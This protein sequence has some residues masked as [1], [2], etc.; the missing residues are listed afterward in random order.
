MDQMQS[1]LPT[2]THLMMNA[3]ALKNTIESAR[4]MTVAQKGSRTTFHT[5]HRTP[6]MCWGRSGL[7]KNNPCAACK[8]PECGKPCRIFDQKDLSDRLHC[9]GLSI[10]KWSLMEMLP[11]DQMLK[12]HH[13]HNVLFDF[14]MLLPRKR[15]IRVCPNC[16]RPFRAA[17]IQ[18]PN[19]RCLFSSTGQSPMNC[20][21]LPTSCDIQE[22]FR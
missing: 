15:H 19:I 18:A 21:D 14:E 1:T 20:Q 11:S 6:Y 9:R 5:A 3:A 4:L 17:E 13:I 12:H 7:R 16:K 22:M 2:K 8:C 10:S